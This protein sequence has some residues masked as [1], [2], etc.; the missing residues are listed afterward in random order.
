MSNNTWAELEG[1]FETFELCGYKKTASAERF[2]V[3]SKND[4]EISVN[5]YGVTIKK[6][7]VFVAH[8]NINDMDY[9][10]VL[11]AL[12]ALQ[13]LDIR[14]IPEYKKMMQDAIEHNLRDSGSAVYNRPGGNAGVLIP[15]K[16][17][18]KVLAVA[19]K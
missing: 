11:F 13:I 1:L 2:V 14:R 12:F 9:G 15:K 6:E 10:T 5:E 3:Y 7:Q 8:L 4:F 18:D 17:N 19:E 16:P